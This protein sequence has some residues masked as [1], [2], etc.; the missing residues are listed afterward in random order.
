M[1][2]TFLLDLHQGIDVHEIRNGKDYAFVAESYVATVLDAGFVVRPVRD[3]GIAA[4]AVFRWRSGDENPALMRFL[5][6][7]H[8]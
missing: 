6:A 8:A 5:E 4:F 2:L 1:A 3:I 7:L